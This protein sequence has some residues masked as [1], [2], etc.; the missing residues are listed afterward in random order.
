MGRATL[1]LLAALAAALAAAPAARAHGAGGALL[2]AGRRRG[3][4][5]PCPTGTR[6]TT[7][8]KLKKEQGFYVRDGA[9]GPSSGPGP[10]ARSTRAGAP[11]LCRLASRPLPRAFAPRL[12]AP[13]ATPPPPPQARGPVQPFVAGRAPSGRA[14]PGRGLGGALLWGCPGD[15]GPRTRP[16]QLCDPA[17]AADPSPAPPPAPHPRSTPTLPQV[18]NYMDYSPDTCLNQFT[19]GQGARMAAQYAAYRFGN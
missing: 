11:P 7:A 9:V 3:N 15:T 5:R 1:V 10:L 4:A 18:Q 8:D 13:R 6:L 14:S 16:P 2:K 12:D 19:A 17:A